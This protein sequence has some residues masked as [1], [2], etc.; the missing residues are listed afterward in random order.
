MDQLANDLSFAIIDVEDVKN[1]LTPRLLPPDGRSIKPLGKDK[2]TTNFVSFTDFANNFYSGSKAKL[3]KPI[4]RSASILLRSKKLILSDSESEDGGDKSGDPL[5]LIPPQSKEMKEI[6]G[7]FGD[8]PASLSRKHRMKKQ[9]RKKES[10]D[11]RLFGQL[12]VGQSN[13]NQYFGKRKRSTTVN[14]Q[15]STSGGIDETHGMNDDHGNNGGNS[16]SYQ[17]NSMDCESQS[18]CDSS[19]LSESVC[20]SDHFAEADDEQSDFHEVMSR[21]KKDICQPSSSNNCGPIGNSTSKPIFRTKYSPSIPIP[22]N[23]FASVPSTPS[24][25][26]NSLTGGSS[27]L[28]KRRR[29]NH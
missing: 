24:S 16:N 26:Y 25:S 14:N 8:Y 17:L 29:R 19:S 27:V 3:S 18:D 13:F 4:L 23:P 9:K 7:P 21:S 5:C 1:D 22:Q 12:C 28:W 10:K 6:P 20:D 11:E 2:L 15:Q